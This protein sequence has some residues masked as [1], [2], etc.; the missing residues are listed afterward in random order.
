MYGCPEVKGKSRELPCAMP[1]TCSRCG[2]CSKEKIGL[3]CKGL[4]ELVRQGMLYVLCV[5]LVVCMAVENI[6]SLDHEKGL[7][8]SRSQ[9]RQLG[10][11][12]CWSGHMGRSDHADSLRLWSLVLFLV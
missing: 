3:G 5:G 7:P 1:L 11:T 2:Y 4:K 12:K 10:C 8:W 6:Q 9:R